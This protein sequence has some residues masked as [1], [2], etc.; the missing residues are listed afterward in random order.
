MLRKLLYLVES[1][2]FV[3]FFEREWDAGQ[4]YENLHLVGFREQI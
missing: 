4:K 3:A 1:P 2:Q